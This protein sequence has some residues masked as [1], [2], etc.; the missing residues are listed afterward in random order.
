M[1]WSEFEA[2]APEVARAG[3][4]LLEDEP[5]VPG[6]AF[7][8]TVGADGRPR[9]HPFV[10]AIVDGGLWAFVITSPK[11]RDL[12]RDGWYSIHSTLGPKDESFLVGGSATRTDAAND[13]QRIAAHMPFSDI[14]ERHVLYEFGVDRA[15]WT[16]WTTPTSPVHHNWRRT[17]GLTD[18]RSP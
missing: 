8:G 12:D 11:Q 17:T 13:R 4:R 5:G 18:P 10:P 15:L 14:D 1:S 9:M 2:A 7:L 16:E 6:V 3:T